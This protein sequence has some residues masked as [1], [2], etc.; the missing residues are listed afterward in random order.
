MPSF[1]YSTNAGPATIDAS[2]RTTAI[3][4]LIQRGIAPSTI[5]EVKGRQAAADASSTMVVVGQTRAAPVVAARRG[6]ISLQETASFIRELATAVS[7]GLP[8]VP[9]LRTLARAGRNP[10]QRAMLNHIIERVE[11]GASLADACKSWGK[12]FDE[13]LINLIKAGEVSGKLPEVLHQ[14]ADL[15]ERSLAM[16]RAVVGATI[17]PAFLAF[18]VGIAI[19]VVTTYIVPT[20]LK[21]LEAQNVPLPLTTKIVKGFA[22]FVGSY[23]WLLIGLIVLAV[24]GWARARSVPSTRLAMDRI[25]LKT[26]LLGPMLGEAAVARFTRT[27]G[28]LVKAGLPV[29][30]ALRLTGATITNTAMKQAVFSVCDQVAGGKTIA[31]PLE[32]T[33]YFPP[34]LVQI[35]SLGERSG[36]LPELLTQAAHSMEER[37]AN[38]IRLFTEALRPLLVI[39]IAGVVAF[40]VA[41][42]LFAL[43]ALQESIG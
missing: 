37:T 3:R 25:A 41:S 36:R 31:D 5:E 35:V 12:P 43:L 13:L 40:V 15:L 38:R 27:L 30:S 34:L 6:S 9:A 4:M 39:I 42:I 16:R 8:L 24:M 22:D 1:R 21:P 32:K 20:V 14:S 23:W 29:L 18:L 28:T 10:A 26:P 19:V 33:G 2:D 17:Y 7:A 11:S